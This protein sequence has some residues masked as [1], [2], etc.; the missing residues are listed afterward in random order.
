MSEE[1]RAPIVIGILDK[2]DMILCCP[3]FENE[4]AGSDRVLSVIIPVLFDGGRGRNH[5]PRARQILQKGR[6][7]SREFDN[8]LGIV[9]HLRFNIVRKNSRCGRC[10]SGSDRSAIQRNFYRL[11]VER[12]SVMKFHI[13][14]K[15]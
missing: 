2:R 9:N 10:H 5:Q 3:L 15:V 14:A 7:R 8:H 12:G 11:G 1:F 13:I 4:G 6:M